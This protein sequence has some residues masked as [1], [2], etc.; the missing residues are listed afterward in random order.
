MEKIMNCESCG[1]LGI[2]DTGIDGAC[3]RCGEADYL[4]D[5]SRE[6]LLGHI[7]TQDLEKLWELL[8]DVPVNDDD[9][10]EGDF[11]WFRRGTH[12]EDVWLWFDEKY[13]GGV[14]RLMFS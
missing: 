9:G 10:I 7:G 5:M 1:W 3:P 2:A 12:K 4:V 13:P 6:C 8:G 11:L 14:Y